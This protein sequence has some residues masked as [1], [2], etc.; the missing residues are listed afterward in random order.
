LTPTDDLL[1]LCRAWL[2]NG[3]APVARIQDW[4]ALRGLAAPHRLH[5]L[6]YRQLAAQAEE[7]PAIELA[8]WAQ[9]ARMITLDNLKRTA[10][11]VRVVL[12]MRERGV[13]PVP[14]KGP[15]LSLELYRDVSFR[16]FSDL[17]LLIPQ[18]QALSALACLHEAGYVIDDGTDHPPEAQQWPAYLTGQRGEIPLVNRD[19]LIQIDLHWRMLS[20]IAGGDDDW[21]LRL[22][23]EPLQLA[24]HAI[25]RLATDYLLVYLAL[26]GFKHGWNRL[27]WL[28][29]LAML[30]VRAPGWD[31]AT[32]RGSFLGDTQ[33][34]LI[35][36]SCLCLV[37]SLL[38]VPLNQE[39]Q[40][41]ALC[42]ELMPKARELARAVGQGI[43]ES[44]G[45]EPGQASLLKYQLM[46][47]PNLGAKAQCLMRLANAVGFEEVRTLGL[48]KGLRLL[49]YPYRWCRLIAKPLR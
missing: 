44:R 28:V 43:Y 2:H 49:Y 9:K 41:D 14:V 22:S 37:E 19:N 18:D 45:R 23:P 20:L 7:V 1:A 8:W 11:L 48:P 33:N 32:L 15:C 46:A 26:H 38:G 24:G 21:S 34:M 3:E 10:E 36:L 35:F 5:P 47:C 31:L 27:A 25:P 16:E 12:L 29:D 17:D 4:A 42:R 13:E 6:I 39:L 30:L 40:E